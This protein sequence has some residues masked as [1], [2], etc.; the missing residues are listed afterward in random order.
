MFTQPLIFDS[1][2]VDE[3]GDCWTPSCEIESKGRGWKVAK[4]RFRCSTPSCFVTLGENEGKIA[5]LE[6]SNRSEPADIGPHLKTMGWH[7]EPSEDYIIVLVGCG[8]AV[9]RSVS[10]VIALF[11]DFC[12]TLMLG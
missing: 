10:A 7:Q 8:V 1:S 4:K 12:A 3:E 5:F 11:D 9:G 2:P 6:K